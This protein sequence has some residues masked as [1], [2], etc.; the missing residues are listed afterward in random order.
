MAYLT[1]NREFVDKLR[2][3]LIL[4]NVNDKM[5]NDWKELGIITSESQFSG[6]WSQTTLY[7]WPLSP[8][9]RIMDGFAGCLPMIQFPSGVSLYLAIS[10]F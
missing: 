2:A 3:E 8:V 6:K 4:H 10:A 1:V 9:A 7:A 5:T